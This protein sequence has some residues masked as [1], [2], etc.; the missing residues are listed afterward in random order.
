MQLCLPHTLLVEPEGLGLPRFLNGAS[1]CHLGFHCPFTLVVI[2]QS[3][4]CRTLC[5]PMDCSIPDFTVHHHLPELAQ[6]HV[7]PVGD[8]I[9]PSHPLLS[10]SPPTFNRS[11]HQGLSF[12]MNE[13]F[14]S[15]AQS[16]GASTSAS[17]LP[18]NIQD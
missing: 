13:L 15:G 1:G 11:Q 9:Q 5:N 2:V 16:I 6:T 12:L 18:M 4:S 3:L 10:P 8:A 7:H 17:V 14:T